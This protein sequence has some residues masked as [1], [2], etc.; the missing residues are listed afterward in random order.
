MQTSGNQK[1]PEPI[2]TTDIIHDSSKHRAPYWLLLAVNEYPSAYCDNHHLRV[3][4]E[5][6]NRVNLYEEWLLVNDGILEPSK[7]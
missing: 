2:N 5:K 3:E 7:A 6:K 1:R 4:A